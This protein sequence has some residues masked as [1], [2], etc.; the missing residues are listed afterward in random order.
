MHVQSVL[1]KARRGEDLTTERLLDV[2]VRLERLA[3]EG[4][5]LVDEVLGVERLDSRARQ[6]ESEADLEEVLTAT[7][8]LHAEA[9]RRAGCDLCIEKEEGVDRIRGR[10]NRRALKSVFSNLLQ[11]VSR[12]AAG[13]PVKI[14]LARFGARARIR[15]SD[16]G[17]GLPP[18]VL[19]SPDDTSARSHPLG[20]SH[21]L[22]I[23]IIHRAVAELD[24]QVE[25][26][27]GPGG[28]LMCE[29]WLP[30]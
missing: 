10:W 5:R 26:R 15:F 21:G 8:S 20:A 9:L 2:M 28:G 22:G 13:A 27:N 6:V 12:Y 17:P 11:N 1:W 16:G 23:W 3:G 14:H 4:A 30:L 25:M 7:I 29:I 19:M 24:G 18:Q